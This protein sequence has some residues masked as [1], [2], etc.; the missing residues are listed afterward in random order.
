M[1]TVT[2]STTIYAVK[3]WQLSLKLIM[4]EPQVHFRSY[5][6]SEASM[7]LNT[8]QA[9]TDMAGPIWRSYNYG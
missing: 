3:D 6:F 5:N 7:A 4:K 9:Q 1:C 8:K 2:V